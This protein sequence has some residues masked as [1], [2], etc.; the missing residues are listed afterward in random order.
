MEL[1][2]VPL[3]ERV[4]QL[5]NVV[6]PSLLTMYETEDNKLSVVPS[7]PLHFFAFVMKQLRKLSSLRAIW[8]REQRESF[9]TFFSLTENCTRD[10][11]AYCVDRKVA[12]S[13]CLC[14]AETLTV[15]GPAFIE[16]RKSFTPLDF[17]RSDIDSVIRS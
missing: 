12:S 17:V 4:T 15:V 7:S 9:L 16:G 2:V 6:L 5:I 1:K 3:D 8:L 13:F 10:A 11:N 14:L